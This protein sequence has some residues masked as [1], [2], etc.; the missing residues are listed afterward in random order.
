MNLSDVRF[1]PNADIGRDATLC[2]HLECVRVEWVGF[3]VPPL[4]WVNLAF[5]SPFSTTYRHRLSGMLSVLSGALMFAS[6]RFNAPELP[7][8][9]CGAAVAML[10][11]FVALLRKPERKEPRR[12]VR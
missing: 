7:L 3:L 4:L 9:L 11:M 10:A 6:L 5:V 2:A 1:S 12:R 8:M